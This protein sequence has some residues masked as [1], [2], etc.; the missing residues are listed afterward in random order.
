QHP[1][2]LLGDND[3][4]FDV[5]QRGALRGDIQRDQIA[6]ERGANDAGGHEHRLE[7][8]RAHAYP[9]W[10][11]AGASVRTA[12]RSRAERARGFLASSRSDGDTGLATFSKVGA[13]P[14]ATCGRWRDPAGTL[15]LRSFRKRLTIRSSR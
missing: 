12:V 13:G 2:V 1:D 4:A 5:F 14:R 11:H 8:V 6:A 15:P 3:L 10:S 9:P 7:A